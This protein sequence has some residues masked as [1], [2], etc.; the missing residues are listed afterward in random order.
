MACGRA[1]SVLQELMDVIDSEAF[2]ECGRLRIISLHEHQSALILRLN[3]LSE[4]RGAVLDEIWEITCLRP[5][6]CVLSLEIAYDLILTSDHVLLWEYIAP[7]TELYFRGKPVDS[8][9]VIGALYERHRA[10]AGT[11]IS[12]DRFLNYI[13]D[14]RNLSQLIGGG[15][16]LLAKGPHQ[17]LSEYAAVIQMHGLH[18]NLL[19]PR[20]P[21]RWDGQRWIP[22]DRDLLVLVIGDSFV[23]AAGFEAQ[24]IVGVDVG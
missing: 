20:P 9:A 6:K 10:T 8:L 1:A 17:L 18:P 22:E 11:W 19:P 16:G 2:D 24:R 14:W 5:R 23:V 13:G 12:F 4:S 3:L 15:Y 7:T 21:V